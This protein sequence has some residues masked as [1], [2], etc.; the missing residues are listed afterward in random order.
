[1]FTHNLWLCIVLHFGL[2]LLVL[3]VVEHG[4]RGAPVADRQ[5]VA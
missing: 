1:V 4:M 5:P 2:R 3:R